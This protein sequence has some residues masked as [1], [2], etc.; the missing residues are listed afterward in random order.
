MLSQA[1]HFLCVTMA[2]VLKADNVK[3]SGLKERKSSL[4]E[5]GSSFNEQA[6]KLNEWSRKNKVEVNSL[7]QM[8]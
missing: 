6:V 4:Q 7:E 3:E 1:K 8:N 2:L 5:F